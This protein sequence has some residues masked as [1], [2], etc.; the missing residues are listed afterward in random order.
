ME[1]QITL[2]HTKLMIMTKRASQKG[3]T[4]IETLLYIVLFSFII[5]GILLAVYNI[6]EGSERTRQNAI[7]EE[8]A[9]FLLRKLTWGLTGV[10]SPNVIAPPVSSTGPALTLTKDGLPVGEN[11]ITFDEVGG[12]VRLTRGS[13]P[14]APLTSSN[15][16]VSGLTITNLGTAGGATGGL[17]IDFQ[18]NGR[19]FQLKKAFR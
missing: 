18:I 4:L 12:A 2:L 1:T 5:T 6:L 7:L 11:P 19:L 17:I 13:N 9:N 16:I 14:A 3:F 10:R 15:V 8:E